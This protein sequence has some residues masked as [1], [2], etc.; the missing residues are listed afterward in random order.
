MQKMM[1]VLVSVVLQWEETQT[2]HSEASDVG[3]GTFTVFLYCD[4]YVGGG[5][6]AFLP[7]LLPGS[8]PAVPFILLDDVQNLMGES[9]WVHIRRRVYKM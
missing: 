7:T 8:R 5:N 6:V 2:D 1:F 3:D 4:F 9:K